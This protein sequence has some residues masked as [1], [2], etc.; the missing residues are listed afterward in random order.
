MSWSDEASARILKHDVKL[1]LRGGMPAGFEL[2]QAPLIDEWIVSTFDQTAAIVGL[3]GGK[4][5]KTTRLVWLDRNYKW[6]RTEDAL[7]RLAK[8]TS[9]IPEDM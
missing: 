5:H 8:P 7:Y 9:K 2:R 6:A 4:R 3:V 1:Y